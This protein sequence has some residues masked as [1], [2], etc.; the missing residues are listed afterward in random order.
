VPGGSSGGS[1]A[2]VAAGLGAASI[3]SD[4]R[5]SIRIPAACCGITGLKP[6]TG[7]V[8]TDGVLPLSATL[9]S[10][11]PMTRSV[12]DAALLLGVL[13]GGRS[14]AQRYAEALERPVRGLRIG[15]AEHLMRDVAGVVASAVDEALRQLEHAGC[16][17]SEVSL[18][19][20]EGA[21]EQSYVIGGAEAAEWHDR[22][23]QERPE[24]F[25]PR[26]RERLMKGYGITAIDYVRARQKRDVVRRAFQRCFREV[27]VLAG[28]ALPAV[29][30]RI[31]SDTLEVD[32]RSEPIID[33]SM[34]LTAPQS[35]GGV[36]ALA[37]PC[38]FGASGLPLG[39]QLVAARYREDLLFTLGAELQRLT[40]WHRRR[41]ALPE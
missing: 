2:A 26:V 9:D 3:G 34:R 14:F 30:A 32:D 37:L 15:V 39:L 16:V 7:L 35:L 13:A 33:G 6:T 5:G 36:P 4:T 11:G 12:D 24:L 23:L 27:D 18:P 8:P 31:G 20:L 25:G 41:P 22:D 1:A 19:E 40:D 28:A 10:V 38:G 29:A 17:R 21:L